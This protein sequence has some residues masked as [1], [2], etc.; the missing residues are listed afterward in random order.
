MKG[1]TPHTAYRRDR[2]MADTRTREQL[3]ELFNEG[4][5]GTLKNDDGQA[6]YWLDADLAREEAAELYP[7]WVR[8][9]ATIRTRD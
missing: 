3:L 2:I 8:K 4:F 7:A 6:H 1:N 5:V 9:G